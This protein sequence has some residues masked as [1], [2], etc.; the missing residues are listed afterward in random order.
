MFSDVLDLDCI[1]I[2]RKDHKHSFKNDKKH[3]SCRI[4][5]TANLCFYVNFFV[6]W[7]C[8]IFLFF[9]FNISHLD[10]RKEQIIDDSKNTSTST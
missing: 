8:E 5:Y 9:F 1:E 6:L 3:T 10:A 4:N 7:Q 2:D